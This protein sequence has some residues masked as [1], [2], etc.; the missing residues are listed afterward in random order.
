MA[1]NTLGGALALTHKQLG[2]CVVVVDAG[3]LT[4]AS[5]SLLLA[6]TRTCPDS[7]LAPV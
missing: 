4:L 5:P 3:V 1:I 7:M 6:Y 2:R